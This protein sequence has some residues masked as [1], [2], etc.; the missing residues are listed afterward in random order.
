LH[1]VTIPH[2]HQAKEKQYDP[3]AYPGKTPSPNVPDVFAVTGQAFLDI[4][5]LLFATFYSVALRH[6]ELFWHKIGLSGIF[7]GGLGVFY[8]KKGQ[9]SHN[10]GR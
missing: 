7:R 1:E 2:Q 9:R 4:L 5:F 3:Q 6:I 10:P 8:V